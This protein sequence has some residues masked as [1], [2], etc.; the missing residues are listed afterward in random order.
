M[1]YVILLPTLNTNIF[2]YFLSDKMFAYNF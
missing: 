2:T 1:G